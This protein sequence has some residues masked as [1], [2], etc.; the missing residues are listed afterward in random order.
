MPGEGVKVKKLRRG[1][2]AVSGRRKSVECGRWKRRL[3]AQSFM[4]QGIVC[5][6]L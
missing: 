5:R 6:S 3:K 1:G 2:S 4:A